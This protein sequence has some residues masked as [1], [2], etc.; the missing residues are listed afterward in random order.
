MW[1]Q[2]RN[3]KHWRHFSPYKSCTCF[4]TTGFCHGRLKPL[5]TAS[6]HSS[7]KSFEGMKVKVKVTQLCPTLC[8]PMNYT[9]H[10]ILQA[11]ILQWVAFPFFRGSSQ[12]RDRTQVSCIAGKFFT[13]WATRE[14]LEGILG[15]IKGGCF[16]WLFT[17]KG[18]YSQRG[19]R[20]LW[21]QGKSSLNVY[22]GEKW[23]SW[24]WRRR[25][26]W[27]GEMSYT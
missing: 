13:S 22:T 9:V 4:E 21:A 7:C 2:L 16:T 12:P 26:C 6:P 18:A 10:R 15:E 19:N 14:A 11:R 1:L 27:W 20:D 23:C 24:R 8:D 5:L 3:C 25:G 17:K